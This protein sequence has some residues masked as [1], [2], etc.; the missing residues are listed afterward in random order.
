MKLKE[1]YNFYAEVKQE[2]K[3]I[4]WPGRQELLSTFMVVVVV[5]LMC[6]LFFL[7]FDYIIHYII[8]LLLNIGK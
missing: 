1:I 5:M 3:K 7:C 4:V 8:T 6:S 2:A